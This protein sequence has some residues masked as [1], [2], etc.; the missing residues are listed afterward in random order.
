MV[1]MGSRKGGKVGDKKG[2]WEVALAGR[3]TWGLYLLNC[4]FFF[5]FLHFPP[6]PPILNYSGPTNHF[7]TYIY[8][9]MY[10]KVVLVI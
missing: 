10:I 4:R 8:R 6:S 5:I 7:N 9:Y 3:A 1:V 2:R